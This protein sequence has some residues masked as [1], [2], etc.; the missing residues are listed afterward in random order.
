MAKQQPNVVKEANARKPNDD[1]EYRDDNPD[2]YYTRQNPFG[3]Y[4]RYRERPDG[5]LGQE[6][7]EGFSTQKNIDQWSERASKNSYPSNPSVVPGT[8]RR[9]R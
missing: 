4:D 2:F 8:G 1:P 3:P 7:I 5:K 9:G 6:Y